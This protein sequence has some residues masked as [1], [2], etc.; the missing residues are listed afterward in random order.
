MMTRVQILLPEDQDR[1][2]EAG[3]IPPHDWHRPKFG[4]MHICW[5][6][7]RGAREP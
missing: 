5:D 2:L 1:R 4:P 7:P 3:N 6:L